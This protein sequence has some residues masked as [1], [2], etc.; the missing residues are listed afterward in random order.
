MNSIWDQVKSYVSLATNIVARVYTVLVSV[1]VIVP[2]YPMFP[3]PDLDP[4]WSLGL[5]EVISKGLH[6]GSDI[7]FT[8][9]PYSSIATKYYHPDTYALIL[10]VSVVLA[11]IFSYFVYKALKEST[12][13][14]ALY[15]VLVPTISLYS[16]DAIFLTFPLLYIFHNSNNSKYE[17][18]SSVLFSL[19]LG[20]IILI[21]GSYFVMTLIFIIII[22]SYYIYEKKYFNLL[23]IYLTLISSSIILWLISGQ[24]IS[25]LTD[26]FIGLYKV[27]DGYSESMS[28]PGPH[29]N[30]L[31]FI[32][33]AFFIIYNIIFNN[34]NRYYKIMYTLLF[35]STFFIL[36]KAG[37]VR[38]DDHIRIASGGLII[39]SLY[40]LRYVKKNYYI[41]LVLV[42][43]LSSIMIGDIFIKYQNSYFNTIVYNFSRSL[44]GVHLAYLNYK[45]DFNNY[46]NIFS[47][48]VRKISM[49]SRLPNQTGSSDLYNHDL[50]K[51][52]VTKNEWQPRPV[53]QSYSAYTKKLSKINLNHLLT[54][55]PDNIFLM[56]N[57]IDGRFPSLDDGASW[58]VFFSSYTPDSIYG[59]YLHLLKKPSVTLPSYEIFSKSK[60]RLNDLVPVPPST[61]PI[62]SRL[63]INKTFF[64][65]IINLTYRPDILH[66]TVFF[67]DGSN[68]RFRFIASMGESP[69]LLS[70]LVE[71]TEDFLHM[72]NDPFQNKKIQFLKL[73]NNGLGTDWENEFVLELIKYDLNRE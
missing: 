56:V 15:S 72:F 26:Y 20:I 29:I 61:E 62:F 4:S 49:N 51:L 65:S 45:S 8:Y 33:V 71:N 25:S 11:T 70:P 46:D 28:Y 36:F 58:P 6:F 69:F 47:E 48:R 64:G 63:I 59:S 43:Y 73:Q 1:I 54:S 57:T 67:E 3:S 37:F 2:L 55:P 22:T 34:D 14:M 23:I 13:S 44:Q 19:F 9:G 42:V 50:T 53:F 52:I 60:H 12:F 16:M 35:I 68:K 39:I 38:Q 10:I 5:N 7:I 30:V 40:S 66:L 32:L 31:L 41:Q 24:Q 18:Y 17:I 21:K 27:T